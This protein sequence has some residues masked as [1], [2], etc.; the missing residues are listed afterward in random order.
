MEEKSLTS[1]IVLEV[2]VHSPTAPVEF[3]PVV[4]KG[5]M[6]ETLS[7]ASFF[8]TDWTNERKRGTEDI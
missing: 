3:C 4:R 5:V 1:L 7:R 8:P 6:Q 2:P